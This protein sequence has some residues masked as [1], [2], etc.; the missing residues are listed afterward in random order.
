M[1]RDKNWVHIFDVTWIGKE[2]ILINITDILWR[3]ND[4]TLSLHGFAS[5]GLK[6]SRIQLLQ[7]QLSLRHFY[8]Q[9]VYVAVEL[10]YSLHN[11]ILCIQLYLFKCK[12]QLCWMR[13][14]HD[15][16]KPFQ[17]AQRYIKK[18]LYQYVSVE[19]A[20]SLDEEIK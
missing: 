12:I 4:K 14:Y 9:P 7:V 6:L 11:G 3:S 2:T 15:G 20:A 18:F 5:C 8:A 13:Q 19:F 1:K 16:H 17:V 10:Q